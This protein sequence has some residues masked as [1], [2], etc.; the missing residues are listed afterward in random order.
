MNINEYQKFYCIDQ[1]F[2]RLLQVWFEVDEQ[3]RNYNETSAITFI[4]DIVTVKRQN[5]NVSSSI[6]SNMDRPQRIT[7]IIKRKF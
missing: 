3:I 7:F 4:I 5:E 6:I 2:Y 1:C